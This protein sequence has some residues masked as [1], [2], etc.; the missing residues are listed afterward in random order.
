MLELTKKYNRG[1]TRDNNPV[2][3]LLLPV[4][5]LLLIKIIFPSVVLSC[6]QRT[7]YKIGN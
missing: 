7:V 5:L 4:V 2:I 6:N 3:I 1:T